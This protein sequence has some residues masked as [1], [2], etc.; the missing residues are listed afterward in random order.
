MINLKSSLSMPVF[1]QGISGNRMRKT[2]GDLKRGNGVKLGRFSFPKVADSGY[3]GL[4]LD[5][6]L[7]TM[8][9]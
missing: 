6:I 9:S 2:F 3:Q 7:A 1:L 4:N 8:I 5:R